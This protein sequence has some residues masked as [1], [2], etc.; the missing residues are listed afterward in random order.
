MN[1]INKTIKPHISSQMK[2]YCDLPGQKINSGTISSHVL[3][4]SQIPD[5]VFFQDKSLFIMALTCPFPDNIEKVHQYK[6]N[7]YSSLV[8]DIE[9]RGFTVKCYCIKISSFG[10]I[11][12]NN[13]LTLRKLLKDIH[14]QAKIKVGQL[15]ND[16]SKISLL[17]SYSIWIIMWM[18]ISPVTGQDQQLLVGVAS[19]DLGGQLSALLFKILIVQLLL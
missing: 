8:Q 12:S 3:P 9:D 5:L 1:H 14:V 13:K 7:K 19:L 2:M 4:S 6:I 17:T 18:K 11:N 15:I 16:L 10:H